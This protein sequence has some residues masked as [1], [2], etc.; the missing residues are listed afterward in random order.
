MAQRLEAS[1]ASEAEVSVFVE[2]LRQFHS[3]LPVHE[4][5]LLDAVLLTAAGEERA[6]EAYGLDG[7]A[8]K[9]ATLVALVALSIGVG[10]LSAPLAGTA[11]ASGLAQPT[12]PVITN[13]I[14]TPA[15]GILNTPGGQPATNTGSIPAGTT[16]THLP[17]GST[18]A[19]AI[20]NTPGGQPVT[21]PSSSPAGPVIPGSGFPPG[22]HGSSAIPVDT[23]VTH[24]P[25]GST[26]AGAIFN[27]PGGQPVTNPG[28]TPAGPAIPSDTVVPYHGNTPAGAIFNT[29]GGQV[30]TNPGSIPGSGGVSTPGGQPVTDPAGTPAGGGTPTGGGTPPSNSTMPSTSQ[31]MPSTSQTAP[32]ST[33]THWVNVQPSYQYYYGPTYTYDYDWYFS[34]H[35]SFPWLYQISNEEPAEGLFAEYY[36]YEG[37]YYCFVG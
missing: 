24:L 30:I 8:A 7:A 12:G 13:P 36:F 22:Y 19:G 33:P 20:L 14:H 29:P 28:S 4:Q 18:P 34:R 21:N 17:S 31:T 9:R 1:S 15:G 35:I 6:V 2:K 26:P 3:T 25:S 37:V 11:Q 32:A 5:Q 27:T 23:T 16:V 10:G